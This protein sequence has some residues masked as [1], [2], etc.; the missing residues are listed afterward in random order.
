MVA[1]YEAA[2]VVAAAGPAG[3]RRVDAQGPIPAVLGRPNLDHP[4]RLPPPATSTG[5]IV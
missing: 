2:P 3:R 5:S 4:R 1:A